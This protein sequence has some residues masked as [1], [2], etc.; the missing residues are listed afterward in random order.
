MESSA[1]HG[2]V[3]VVQRVERTGTRRLAIVR[4]VRNHYFS[5]QQHGRGLLRKLRKNIKIRRGRT[6]WLVAVSLLHDTA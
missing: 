6:L 5:S 1:C 2:T 3:K 4:R